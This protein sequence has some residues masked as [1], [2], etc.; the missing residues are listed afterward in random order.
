M[1][2]MYYGTSADDA[3]EN[4]VGGF[5][6]LKEEL[7]GGPGYV[8][9]SASRTV[10][11]ADAT[12]RYMAKWVGDAT[13]RWVGNPNLDPEK[14]HQA[15]IGLVFQEAGTNFSTS[16]FYNNV[17]DFILYD[18]AH[19][20]DGILLSDRAVIY[21]NIDAKFHGVELE[22]TKSWGNW[23][24]GFG[25]AYVYSEND[26]DGR[27]IAQT[28]P[29]EGHFSLDYENGPFS[30]GGIVRGAARQTRVDDDASTGSG[31][32]AG[33]TGSWG[34]LDLHLGYKVGKNGEIELGIK[35]VFDE[36]YA[37]HLNKPNSFDPAVTQ[38]N[39]PGR[40]VWAG[41]NLKF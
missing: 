39:E 27:P 6:R 31:L 24:A 5:V 28:P 37:Q 26:T 22:L 15:E 16:V 33:K 2:A 4:N 1:F 34:T 23:S 41:V 30:A 19:G 3:D 14:H 21:R 8:Y 13:K 9:V 36:E 40:S 18:R 10:R 17:D 12:E 25:L 11:T 29:L 7:W 20:Q 38:I 35:N 32:D